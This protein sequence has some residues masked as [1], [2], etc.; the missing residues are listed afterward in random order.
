[1]A[2]VESKRGDMPLTAAWLDER[3]AEYG[4]AHVNDCIRRSLAGEAGYFYAIEDGHVL[5][6]PFPATH[7]MAHWQEYALICGVHYA[8]FLRT[9]DGEMT[10]G[11]D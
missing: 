2:K 8:A 3:R 11:T 6:V 5:G 4:K 10:H 1:M 9:P 7:A